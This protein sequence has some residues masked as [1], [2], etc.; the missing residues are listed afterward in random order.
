[1]TFIVGEYT[2]HDGATLDFTID[3]SS[4]LSSDT[5]SGTPTWTISPAGLTL[6]S[7]TNS[8][9][10]ATAWLTGGV[11]G[12]Q[13]I[14]KNT[15]VTAG[16]RTEV[17]ALQ[18]T[19]GP[20]AGMVYLVEQLRDLANAGT[21]YNDGQLQAVLDRYR[22]DFYR[23]DIQYQL[24]YENGSAVYYNAYYYP[25][26]IERQDTGNGTTTAF[27]IT[28]S[29]GT[30]LGTSAYTINYEAGQIAF[31]SDQRGTTYYLTG[32]SYNVHHAAA[33]LWRQKAA[34][35]AASFEWSSDNHSVKR[36]QVYDHYIKQADRLQAMGGVSIARAVRTDYRGY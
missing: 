25:K 8:T 33:D 11:A 4:F 30:V 15:V 20:R 5:I 32:R 12:Q 29:R 22:T 26:F 14:V 18:V 10:T 23:A 28:D 9:T 1:M 16:G 7:Q 27:C 6:S 13:Y 21:A 2:K 36:N 19:V 35:E 31:T 3:W 17:K 24:T 34:A